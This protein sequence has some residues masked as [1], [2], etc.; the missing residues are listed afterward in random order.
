MQ[1]TT[2]LLTL[3]ALQF[4]IREED[5]KEATAKVKKIRKEKAEV[6]NAKRSLRPG[7]I[8]KSSV[9]LLHDAIQEINISTKRK[10]NYR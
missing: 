5:L 8:A 7:K 9:I 2:D 10:L 3:R 1:S 4:K 6:F